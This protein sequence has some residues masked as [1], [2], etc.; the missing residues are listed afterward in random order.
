MRRREREGETAGQLLLKSGSLL[1]TSG[2]LSFCGPAGRLCST[3]FR[4]VPQS[5][6]DV[7]LVPLLLVGCLLPIEPSCPHPRTMPA[8][9]RLAPGPRRPGWGKGRRECRSCWQSTPPP[10]PSWARALTAH[11]VVTTAPSQDPGVGRLVLSPPLVG[12]QCQLRHVGRP[13]GDVVRACSAGDEPSM[14]PLAQDWL[15]SAKP[16][17]RSQIGTE[18][19]SVLFFFFLSHHLACGIL[20]S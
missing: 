13:W 16:P 1:W 4:I 18:R 9:C 14:M 11:T 6:E 3:R 10:S 17:S 8:S 7:T 20:A 2:I 15:A 5:P 12:R 19:R